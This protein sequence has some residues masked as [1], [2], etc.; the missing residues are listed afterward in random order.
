MISNRDANR[1][2][3]VFATGSLWLFFYEEPWR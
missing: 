1:R 2:R 3:R